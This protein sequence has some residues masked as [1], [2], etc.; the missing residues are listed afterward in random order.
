[1]KNSFMIR[2]NKKL[3]PLSQVGREDMD[4]SK[5]TPFNAMFCPKSILEDQDITPNKKMFSFKFSLPSKDKKDEDFK[6]KGKGF[7]FNTSSSSLKKNPLLKDKDFKDN[8]DNKDF[9]DKGLFK[10]FQSKPF[11]NQPNSSSSL[12]LNI[13]T[14][15]TPF[16]PLIHLPPPV[17]NSCWM[18]SILTS[19]FAALDINQG[20]KCYDEIKNILLDKVLWG[21]W[22]D[23]LASQRSNIG[24]PLKKK[25]W[26]VKS[27]KSLSALN[28]GM[29]S[30]LDMILWEVYGAKEENPSPKNFIYSIVYEKPDFSK[31]VKSLM[32]NSELIAVMMFH[33]KC[34]HWTSIFQFQGLFYYLNY[35][36]YSIH[37]TDQGLLKRIEKEDIY[38]YM[39][40]ATQVIATFCLSSALRHNPKSYL[41]EEE[42]GLNEE[43]IRILDQ[44]IG[45][46]EEEVLEE[47]V[48]EEED[49]EEKEKIEKEEIEIYMDEEDDE[50]GIEAGDLIEEGDLE[51]VLEV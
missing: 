22:L 49:L 23:Y 44:R 3:Q 39:G 21:S 32:D 38:K 24:N 2:K 14:L 5:I 13:N 20:L 16:T 11:L 18:V 46:E 35:P 26:I 19:Y 9:K 17:K 12:T 36:H 41:K 27:L 29:Q 42:E 50:D 47:E 37:N 6:D 10:F 1:M 51:E 30:P 7:Y 31:E 43:I 33:A 48:L 34:P 8:K 40:K 28:S 25:N 15:N 45:E 4:P